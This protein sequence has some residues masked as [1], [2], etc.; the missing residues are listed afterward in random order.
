MA[1]AIGNTNIAPTNLDKAAINIGNQYSNAEDLVLQ[2]YALK[3]DASDTEVE[4]LAKRLNVTVKKDPTTKKLN[5]NIR[6]L[7][8]I[9]EQRF[10]R[11]GQIL[12]LFSNLLDKMN[13]LKDRLI[14]NV[15]R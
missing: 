14:N 8:S 9:A 5:V 1:E 13:Q 2:A 4:A 3:E 12:T 6:G 15:G 11:A 7:Q 10:Q